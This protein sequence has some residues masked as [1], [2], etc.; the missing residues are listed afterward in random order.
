[1]QP[2]HATEDV[3]PDAPGAGGGLQLALDPQL[4]GQGDPES[5]E[6]YLIN[7]TD[8]RVVYEVKASWGGRQQWAKVGKL[9]GYGK[10][11]LGPAPYAA[12]SEKLTYAV[13]VRELRTNGTGPRHF[14]DLRIKPK[15]FFQTLQDVPELFREAHLYVVFPALDRREVTDHPTETGPSLKS[16]TEQEVVKQKSGKVKQDNRLVSTDLRQRVEFSEELDLHLPAL[17]DDPAAVP[18][19]QV[20]STQLRFFEEYI[21]RALR[22]GVDRVYIIH[23]VGSGILKR[24]I[25][26]RLRGI[27][28]VREFRNEY[29]HKYGYGA[30]EVTFS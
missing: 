14:R 6:A 24:E 4:D 29:H 17:V 23:G 25:H 15:F 22:L 8:R 19:N 3:A 27:Q 9:E 10:R 12:L 11:K 7:A 1:M 5:Y 16:L 13:D 20:L 21:D 28:F 2:P 18:R 30:T 26:K